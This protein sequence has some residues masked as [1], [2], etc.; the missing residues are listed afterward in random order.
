M[1]LEPDAAKA[2]V[3]GS[4]QRDAGCISQKR[5]GIQLSQG[6]IAGVA[7]QLAV[8]VSGALAQDAQTHTTLV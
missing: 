2:E 5:K 3:A 1:M 4:E 7:F 6:A 8:T